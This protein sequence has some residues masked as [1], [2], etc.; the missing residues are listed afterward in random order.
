MV[1]LVG[2]VAAACCSLVCVVLVLGVG[3]A[4]LYVLLS[5]AEYELK[6]AEDKK[7]P[8]R[9]WVQGASFLL[10]DG[11]DYA[12]MSDGTIG[13][14]LEDAWRITGPTMLEGEV[15]RLAAAP[16]RPAWNLV[17]AMLLLRAAVSMG[18]VDNEDSFTRCAELGERLQE[19]Y[20]GWEPMAADLLRSR[21]AW[22]GIDLDGADDDDD[23]NDMYEV[24]RALDGLRRSHYPTVPW[25]LAL[26]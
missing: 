18:W 17:R 22:L 23:D 24:T 20:D 26:R 21:R 12:Y 9:A 6:A 15:G 25:A 8:R 5:P 4:A 14:M 2:V 19:H 11:D 16:D 10:M 13:V 7:E 3:V 1:E